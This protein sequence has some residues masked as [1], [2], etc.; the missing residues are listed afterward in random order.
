MFRKKLV[1]SPMNLSHYVTNKY[2]ENISFHYKSVSEKIYSHTKHILYWEKA[3]NLVRDCIY[4][5]TGIWVGATINGRKKNVLD[6]IKPVNVD[7]K[8]LF[9]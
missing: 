4:Q 8:L 5:E 1:I 6:C 9:V 2:R 7:N 3:W